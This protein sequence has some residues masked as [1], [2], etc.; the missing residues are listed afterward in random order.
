MRRITFTTLQKIDSEIYV[1]FL[2]VKLTPRREK[3]SVE[4]LRFYKI[5]QIYTY[6]GIILFNRTWTNE[7]PVP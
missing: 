3:N 7:P 6:F 1:L 2:A 4:Q 5:N